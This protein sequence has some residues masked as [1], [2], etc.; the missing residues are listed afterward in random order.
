MET[1]DPSKYKF[2]PHTGDIKFQAYG[3]SM[4]EMF[5]NVTLAINHI[6]SRGDKII[7][8]KKK[9]IEIE[10]DDNKSLLY[11]FI[12]ELIFLLDSEGFVVSKAK[13]RVNGNKLTAELSGDE[14][15]NY[16]LDQIKAATYAEMH[17]EKKGDKWE[18]QTV[19][20]V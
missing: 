5:E 16:N 3:D 4:N 7:S 17:I 12:E 9:K 18:A 19:V 10:G 11:N 13:V 1:K 20:D 2:F 8:K 15:S 6:L 14:A